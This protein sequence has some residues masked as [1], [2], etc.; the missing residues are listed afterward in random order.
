MSNFTPAL[1]AQL[2]LQAL[3]SGLPLPILLL[4]SFVFF[5]FLPFVSRQQLLLLRGIAFSRYANRLHDVI[6]TNAIKQHVSAFLPHVW[7][8]N[9][10]KSSTPVASCVFVAGYNICESPAVRTSSCSSKWGVIAATKRDL[11]C[12]HVRSPDGLAGHWACNYP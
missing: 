3:S 1:P 8:I 7:V 6:K 12:R 5:S 2:F 9:E 11:H 4:S 10:T